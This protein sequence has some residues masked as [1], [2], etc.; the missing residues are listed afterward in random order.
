MSGTIHVIGAGLAGLA[1]A[2]ALEEQGA[3]IVI[4]EATDHAGGRCRSYYEPALET[5]IDNGNHLL[6]SGNHAAMGYLRRIGAENRLT[7]PAR[8]AFDFADLKT[9]ERWQLRPNEGRLP[10]WILFPG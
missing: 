7:G 6:L 3:R 1:A 5:R 9:G 2:L 8:A 10:W 4:H